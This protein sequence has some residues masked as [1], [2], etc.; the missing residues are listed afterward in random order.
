[1][2]DS[3]TLNFSGESAE[4]IQSSLDKLRAMCPI[5]S[6]ASDSELFSILINYGLEAQEV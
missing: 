4:T 6:S 3:I 1:M 2:N 5:L